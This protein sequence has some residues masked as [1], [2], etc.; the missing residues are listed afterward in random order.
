MHSI[1]VGLLFSVDKHETIS[2]VQVLRMGNY[3][4]ILWVF[5]PTFYKS[6][7][8]QVLDLTAPADLIKRGRE[9]GKKEGKLK[10]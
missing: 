1:I 9:R 6:D 4:P 8:R 7:F 3:L 2:A 10:K 5:Y